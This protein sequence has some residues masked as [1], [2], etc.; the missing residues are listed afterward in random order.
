MTAPILYRVAADGILLLHALFAGFVV[1]GLVLILAGWWRR[2]SWVSNPWFRLAHL[3]AIAVVAAQAW[4]GMLCPL[5]SLEMALRERAGDAV[6]AGS[7]IAHWL[8]AMLYYRAPAWVFV[9]VYTLFGAAV[10]ASWFLVPPRSFT[11]RG[12]H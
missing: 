2:W 1:V 7:F 5:T 4:F 8:E 12:R 6:Y 9:L 11:R 3:L 10:L